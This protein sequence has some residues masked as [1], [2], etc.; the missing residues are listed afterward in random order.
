MHDTVANKITTN[1]VTKKK[2]E[3]LTKEPHNFITIRKLLIMR[4]MV[5]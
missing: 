2:K 4:M 5:M 1:L 3:T